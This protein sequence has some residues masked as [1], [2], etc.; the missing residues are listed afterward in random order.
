MTHNREDDELVRGKTALHCINCD[1][2]TYLTSVS[3]EAPM[4]SLECEDTFTGEWAK[5]DREA[6]EWLKR[7]F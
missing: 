6:S 5:A 2:P 1:K 4:C 7:L 3:F